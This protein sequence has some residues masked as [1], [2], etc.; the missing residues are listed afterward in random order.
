MTVSPGGVDLRTGRYTADILDLSIGEGGAGSIALKRQTGGEHGPGAHNQDRFGQYSANWDFVLKQYKPCSNCTTVGDIS[1]SVEGVSY[2]FH[3]NND[4]TFS[5]TSY[6][7]FAKLVRTMVGTSQ[8]Y[9][10]LTTSAGTVV[11]FQT[12]A[13]P[14]TGS[15]FT[16]ARPITI[17][18]PD[19]VTYTF[20]YSGSSLLSVVSN[21]GYK[22]ILEHAYATQPAFITKA[23]VVNL[24]KMTAGTT[25]PAGVQT[26]SYAYSGNWMT[27]AVDRAGANWTYAA[28]F[29][30][31]GN[32]FT[33]QQFKPGD[34]TPFVTNTWGPALAEHDVVTAQDFVDGRH[35]DYAYQLETYSITFV[36]NEEVDKNFNLG[37][38]WTVNGTVTHNVAWGSDGMQPPMITPTPVSVVDPLGRSFK[39]TYSMGAGGNYLGGLALG[40]TMPEGDSETYTYD[41][42]RNTTSVTHKAKPLSGLV[43]IV[44]SSTFGNCSA[45][46]L[47]ACNQ[48]T[49]TVDAK[50]NATDITYSATHG[51][52]LTASMPADA[53]GIRPVKRYTYVQ[54]NAWI[55]N[56]AGG[57]VQA[58][59]P[60]WLVSEERTCRATATVGSACA[61]GTVDEVVTAYDYGPNSGPNNL[62]VRGVAVT[63]D[64]QT[65]RTCFRYDDYGR[66]LS[67]TKPL[68]T[69]ATCP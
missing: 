31:W 60:I 10:T 65:L 32:A 67:E 16:E 47:I 57:Y 23:C 44:T 20:T 52:V 45:T 22:L 7:G 14:G 68:G 42:Y 5:L 11:V 26:T 24:A 21:A 1:I 12:I 37:I 35:I 25:C 18:H 66:K 34:A 63:A 46:S 64:G 2:N 62:L 4:G 55:S 27:S 15:G 40:R 61:G 59:P 3:D 53:N 49:Q 50:G 41:A 29:V 48:P 28:N 6:A 39:W 51:G 69:G 54:R 43:D 19:G 58:T 56:G 17:T 9:Y 33:E 30:T 8:N 13:Y 36:N 38:G